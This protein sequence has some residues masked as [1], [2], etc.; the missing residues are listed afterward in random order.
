MSDFTT[1]LQRRF[2]A[3]TS[4]QVAALD[5]AA[6]ECGVTVVQLMEIAGWQ[7]ARCAWHAIGNKPAPIL[8]VAGRGNNGGDG[9]VA[10]RHLA[11]WGCQ[12][13][14]HVLAE[15]ARI[16]GLVAEHFMAAR[17]CGAEVW[18]SEDVDELSTQLHSAAL[19]LDGLLGTGL[20][21]DPR[22]PQASAI[23]ALNATGLRVLSIDVPSGLDATTGRVPSAC[24]RA[25][26]TCSL[27]AMKA[28]LWA[29]AARAVAGSI[30]V[31]DIGMPRAAWER[32]GLNQPE[33]VHGGGLVP[34]P[35]LTP[36]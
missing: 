23:R 7:V 10:V 2:G 16:S 5:R 11:T 24:V 32:G 17:A 29:P 18:A 36:P 1:D 27:A 31:G 20:R 22:E 12:V 25:Q 4:E 30:V 28:G 13:R 35:S 3:L 6:V 34:V 8:V 14:A 21:A 33:D 26:I 9:L 19:V 15:P